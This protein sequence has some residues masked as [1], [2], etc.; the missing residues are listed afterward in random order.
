MT[1]TLR[2]YQQQLIDS[3]RAEWNAGH[4]NVLAVMPTRSGKTVTFAALNADGTPSCTIVHRQEL[5]G[6]ISRTYAVAGTYHNIIAPQPVINFCIQQHIKTT[7]RNYFDPR[8]TVHVA[9]V[10]TLIR[11]FKPDDR[12]CAGIK[13]WTC[14]EA[15][16]LLAANK[17]GKAAALF[18]HAHGLGVTATPIRA[19][20]KSL[21]ADQTG[22]FHALVQGP[23][24]RDL[25]ES[26][27]VCDYRIIA[28]QSGID[29][30]LLR[31]GSTGDFTPASAKAAQKSELVG[32]IVQ[33][34][35]DRVQG[36]QAIVFAVDVQDARDIA[37]RF[38]SAGV[39]AESLDGTSNDAHRQLQVDRFARG[40]LRVLTNVDLFGEGFDV[41]ACDVV[42]MARPTAS[43]GL[44]CQQFA[45]CLTP[46]PGKT[47][48]IIIDHVGNV[49]R[50]A[51]THGMPDTP[52][53]WT[54]WQEPGKA[55]QRNADAVPVRVCPACALAYPALSLSCPYCGEPHVPA[56]RGTPQQVDGI[57]SE[58]SPEL[59]AQLRAAAANH[60]A[61]EP[62]VPYGASDIVRR[63]VLNRHRRNQEAQAA[64]ADAMKRWGGVRRAAGDDDTAMQAR[65]LHRFG[66]DVLTAQGLAETAALELRDAIMESLNNG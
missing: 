9:G 7:G 25:I 51:A 34:Y 38:Q 53:R 19:D 55:G 47:H 49:M 14:D 59:L 58:M 60:R 44:F 5:V 45:R 4:R 54:L 48:G 2:P 39:D 18:P 32:D 30:A 27:A 15:H 22:V 11:R 12:W 31:V 8:A 66:V 20:R 62:A 3:I 43:F 21:H 37:A 42:I 52:R 57:L 41:P 1:L 23:G 26:G 10:D 33:T 24:M 63:G 61:D 35:L 29:E 13:R 17:W 56:G 50:M 40:E 16:H 64:L 36:Q 6:Q 28:P 65:F 46:A